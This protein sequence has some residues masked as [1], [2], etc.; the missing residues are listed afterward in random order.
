MF[1]K[2][3]LGSEGNRKESPNNM[4]KSVAI[5]YWDASERCGSHPLIKG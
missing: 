3:S 2:L 1:Y 5:A 4:V